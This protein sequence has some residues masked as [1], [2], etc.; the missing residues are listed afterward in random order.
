MNNIIKEIEDAQ[1]KAEVADFRVGDTV[2]VYAKVIEAQES[3]SRYS[4]VQ[5]LKD[6]T[7]EQER[8]LQLESSLTV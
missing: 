2:K 4:R 1:L 6:R 5:Y 8:H 3:V 7:V